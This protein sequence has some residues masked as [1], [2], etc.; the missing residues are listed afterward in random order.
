[1]PLVQSSFYP[2]D[3]PVHCNMY[4]QVSFGYM[5]LLELDISV[6]LY[7]KVVRVSEIIA[8]SLARSVNL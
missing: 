2:P 4:F 7:Q 8:E 1:M 6:M 5:I 3:T